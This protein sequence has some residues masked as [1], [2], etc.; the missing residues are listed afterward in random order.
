MRG[1][2]SSEV[3]MDRPSGILVVDKPVGMTSHDVVDRVRRVFG[4]RRVGPFGKLKVGHAGTLDPLASGVLLVLVGAATKKSQELVGL[5][6]E[7]EIKAELGWATD[8]LDADG[9][10]IEKW[11]VEDERLRAIGGRKVER[12]LGDLRGKIVQQVPAYS[13][14]KR[15]G[16]KLYKRARKGEQVE[17]PRRKVEVYELVL[18]GLE[19]RKGKYPEV[20]LVTTV[21]SGTYTRSLVE[22]MGRRLGVPAVQTGLV[23]RKV[24]KFS[25]KEA[26]S[27]EKLV[28][29]EAPGQFL[30]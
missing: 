13:A 23:R 18:L 9:K 4:I 10:V 27:W 1:W 21:S 24:G 25:L 30:V 11:R 16:K 14:V 2:W 6:K 12:V 5:P 3:Q 29:S 7:Y 15:G 20:R 22:E 28:A 8:S 26:V 17:R 19:R